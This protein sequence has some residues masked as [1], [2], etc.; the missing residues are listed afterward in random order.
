MLGLVGIGLGPTL[1]GILSDHYAA[2]AFT[3]GAYAVICPGGRAVAGSS[4][5]L[6]QACSS[7]SALGIKYALM[8]LSLLC[9]WSAAH[10]LLA[11]RSLRRDLET[12]YVP[13]TGPV[14]AAAR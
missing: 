4:A 7:A 1:L 11:A 8:T 12:H 9:L 10:Y 5:A 14:P 2:H 13:E 3:L 6:A